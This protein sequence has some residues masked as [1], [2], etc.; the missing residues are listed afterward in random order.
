M[1]KKSGKACT[2]P[3]CTGEYY[4]KGLCDAHYHQ[5]RRV[6]KPPIIIVPKTQFLAAELYEEHFFEFFRDIMFRPEDQWRVNDVLHREMADFLQD[7]DH[8]FRLMIVPRAFMK[9]AMLKAYAIWRLLKNPQLRFLYYCGTIKLASRN[10]NQIKRSLLY[11]TKIV[12]LWPHMRITDAHMKKYRWSS[13]GIDIPIPSELMIHNEASIEIGSVQSGISG[14]HYDE[15]LKDDVV[16]NENCRTSKLRYN[17][18]EG[19]KELENVV[20]GDGYHTTV[21]TRWHYD[22]YYGS[23]LSEELDLDDPGARKKYEYT[24]FHRR[25]L[26][27]D[28][29]PTYPEVLDE[30]RMKVLKRRLGTY[31]YNCQYRC[32]PTSPDNAIFDFQYMRLFNNKYPKPIDEI[33]P[34]KAFV[35]IDPI[36]YES[37]GTDRLAVPVIFV[38]EKGNM[39]LEEC[40]AGRFSD[41]KL[42][43]HLNMLNQKLTL[44]PR[45]T[46]IKFG[47]QS[48]TFEQKYKKYLQQEVR[49]ENISFRIH[50]VPTPTNRSKGQRISAM[51]MFIEN[52]QFF[53]R[54]K[55]DV[56]IETVNM[57]DRNAVMRV[58]QKDMKVVYEEG[59]VY[60]PEYAETDDIWDAIS[61]IQYFVMKVRTEAVNKYARKKQCVECKS[62]FPL[63]Q[64][65]T[66][67][68]CGKGNLKPVEDEM[69][70]ARKWASDYLQKIERQQKEAD[71]KNYSNVGAP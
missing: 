65:G 68:Q 34:V 12:E 47:M 52:G 58:L 30:T 24:L 15:A 57:E 32:E 14:T 19:V 1:K 8:H 18:K 39:F 63:T 7:R 9:S 36:V 38:D 66:C 70:K 61:N 33:A 22:D 44:N 50:P 45:V 67:P 17:V 41:I 26:K 62:F 49:R 53:I 2:I 23:I 46:T 29:T 6:E 42:I 69:D 56:D 64:L 3:A 43:K 21:G 27:K 10:L 11:N 28:G 35:F 20:L 25:D 4:A 71:L 54:A 31:S 13:E 48:F 60:H 37:K 40:K 55:D 5:N 16:N 51:A 59:E